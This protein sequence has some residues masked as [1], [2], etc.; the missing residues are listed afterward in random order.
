MAAPRS[1]GFGITGGARPWLGELASALAGFGYDGAWANDT[2]GHSG[3]E[4]LAGLSGASMLDLGI[5]VVSLANHPPASVAASVRTSGVPPA[6]L[7]LGVGSGGSSSLT[8]MR[9][10]VAALRGELP[11]VR[12]AVAALGPRMS[13]LAGEVADVVLLNWATPPRIAWARERIAAGASRGERHMPVVAAYV[14]V[15]VGEGAGARLATERDRYA[16]IP[17]Y[18]RM[19]EAAGGAAGIAF[20]KATDLAEALGPYREA[21]DVCV[22]RGLPQRDSLEEW[23]AIAEPAVG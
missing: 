20:E 22:V 14:R 11:G 10:G 4:A 5:G 13:E 15:A 16:R 7:I 6:R 8:L 12:L 2:P 1:L 3:I 21:L 23:L 9:E 17:S 19:F 18:A